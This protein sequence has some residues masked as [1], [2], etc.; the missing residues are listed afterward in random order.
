MPEDYNAR[1]EALHMALTFHRE[2]SS[3]PD[4]VVA[5]ADLFTRFLNG[6]LEFS[7]EE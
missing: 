3:S 6:E 7:N 2:D 1:R 5:T 4:E